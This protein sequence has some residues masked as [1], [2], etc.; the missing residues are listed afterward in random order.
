MNAVNMFKI[1]ENN[2]FIEIDISWMPEC[3]FFAVYRLEALGKISF[4]VYFSRHR[5][6]NLLRNSL[7]CQNRTNHNQIIRPQPFLLSTL[8]DVAE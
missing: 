2:I 1:S 3:F 8:A 6:K 5:V 7:S 4:N